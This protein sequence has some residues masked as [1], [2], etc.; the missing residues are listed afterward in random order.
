MRS[1]AVIGAVSLTLAALIVAGWFG[2]EMFVVRRSPRRARVG[3]H[4]KLLENGLVVLFLITACLSA[5]ALFE[6][7]KRGAPR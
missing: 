1:T 6:V 5:W 2:F 3:F 4:Q 7:F